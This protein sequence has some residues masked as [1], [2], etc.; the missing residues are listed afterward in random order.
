MNSHAEMTTRI[1]GLLTPHVG[2]SAF[3]VAKRLVEAGVFLPPLNA[4]ML[5]QTT[6]KFDPA[7]GSPFAGNLTMSDGRVFSDFGGYTRDVTDE[8]NAW[9]SSLPQTTTRA[10]QWTDE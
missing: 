10:Y 7:Q 4:T 2:D 8:Y 9:V 1:A 5:E 6:G 3:D